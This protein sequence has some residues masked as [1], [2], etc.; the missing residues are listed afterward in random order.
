VDDKVRELLQAV[1]ARGGEAN[2]WEAGQA[3]GLTRDQTEGLATEAMGESLL[4]MVS[5]SG[6]VRLTEQG[7]E[8]AGAGQGGAE[9]S[10]L[11]GLVSQAAALGEAGLPPAQ[12]KDL[13]ADLACLQAQLGR[14]RPL[15][16]VVR[17]CLESLAGLLEASSQEAAH[18]LAARARVLLD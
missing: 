17:A 10:G 9:E 13:A 4:E 1:Q 7:A 2:M 3:L 18:D 5:L 16:A 8:A 11:S 14:S 15:P 12:A 6:K